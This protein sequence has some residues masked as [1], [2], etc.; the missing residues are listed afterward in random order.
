MT[1]F[2]QN[3]RG[4]REGLI[5]MFT[6][7]ELSE[8]AR[9]S[10]EKARYWLKLLDLQPVKKEGKLYYC[11]GS[12]DLLT[13]MKQLVVAGLPPVAAAG[14]AKHVCPKPVTAALDTPAPICNQD[15][16]KLADLEKAILLMAATIERQG[17]MIEQQT[18]V[19]NAQSSKIETLAAKLLP[20]PL[21]EVKPVN[22]WQ[23]IAKK[24]QQVSWIKRAWLELVNP[25]QLRAI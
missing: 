8:K 20:P 16:G 12:D 23:P 10:K 5:I 19:I 7:L 18:S 4:L 14:E 11:A 17:K 1:R 3:L 22:V 13:A 2:C 24:P 6:I 25:V 21:A 9:V 15:S